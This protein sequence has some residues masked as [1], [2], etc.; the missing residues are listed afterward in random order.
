MF[1]VQEEKKR[2]RNH[3]NKLTLNIGSTNPW[4][5]LL[6][7]PRPERGFKMTSI[8][9]ELLH[10]IYDS[11]GNSLKIESKLCFLEAIG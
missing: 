4:K 5:T 3:Q 6:D 10:L 2:G 7:R 8:L 9:G 11:G 1:K